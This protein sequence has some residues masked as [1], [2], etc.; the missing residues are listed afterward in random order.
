MSD[1][2]LYLV[3]HRSRWILGVLIG[4]ILLL[5]VGILSIRV[6]SNLLGNFKKSSAIRVHSDQLHEELSG[7]Q[8]FSIVFDGKKEAYF[9]K[10]ENLKKLALVQEYIAQTGDFDIS[11]S[12]ADHIALINR[13]ITGGEQV[14][15]VIPDQDDLVAQY[16]LFFTRADLERYVSADYRY[17]SIQVRHN[18]DTSSELKQVLDELKT[19]IPNSIEGSSDFFITGEPLLYEKAAETITRGVSRSLSLILIVIF[20]ITSIL[21]ARI[22][23][24]FLAMV[25]NLIPI[26][27]LFG[28][29]GHFGITLNI[30]TAIVAACAIGL[31][32][33]DTIHLFVR[34]HS[35]MKKINNR[36]DAV[37]SMIRGEIRPVVITSVGLAI[38]FT[39]LG[40]SSFVPTIQFGLLGALVIIV[41]FFTDLLVTPILLAR[42]K[43]ISIWDLLGLSLSQNMI[44]RSRLFRDMARWQ[45]KRVVLLGHLKDVRSGDYI[46]R[47][48]EVERTMYMIIKGA[49]K[50]EIM[51]QEHDALKVIELHEGDVF[52][53]IA[54]VNEMART[55]NV[56]AAGDSTV[57]SLDWEDLN[58]IG[59][60]FPRISTKLF[61]NISRILGMRLAATDKRLVEMSD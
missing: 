36:I 13:E 16:F 15:Y 14:S 37:R 50:V 49:A 42:T 12:A 5:G 23:A 32:V 55:A 9:K 46:I 56:I 40:L 35:N 47:Q 11:I 22:K 34:Y 6:N 21:F 57:L 7:A 43:L 53:E 59:K 30:G 28:I 3:N 58:R 4:S 39:F 33:D 45:I 41:A 10:A 48:G 19:F 17:A 60:I 38:G 61:L 51:S 29:L 8:S 20:L 1:Y 18:I 2:V 24:G 52:G 27:F 31:A 25:P 26:L 54:L 44:K